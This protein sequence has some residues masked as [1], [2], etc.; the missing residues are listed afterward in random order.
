M[1]QHITE[2]SAAAK[3]LYD[4]GLYQKALDQYEKLASA[5]VKDTELFYNMGN[6]YVRLE[7]YGEAKLYFERALVFDP[8]N[9]DA[10]HNLDWINLRLADTLI[11]PSQ[12]LMEWLSELF[13]GTLPEEV[14]MVVGSFVL[15]FSFLLLLWKRF[16]NRKINWRIPFTTSLIGI[17]LLSVGAI[18][19]P[20]ITKCIVVEPNSYGYSEP[21][22]GGKR[23]ILLSEGSAGKLIRI[24]GGW[25]LIAIEDERSAWFESEQWKRIYPEYQIK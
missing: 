5:G 24:Q 23:I 18:S 9:N 19:R 2:L 15:L 13:R 20:K 6:C 25:S 11:E 7:E 12:E 22:A 8:S 14:W 3:E 10:L 21:F 16:S 1:E 4:Q 17:V